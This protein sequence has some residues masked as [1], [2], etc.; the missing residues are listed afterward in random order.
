MITVNN[1]FAH[2]VKEISITKYGSDK[3]LPPKFT[4]W[5]IYQYSDSMLKHLPADSLKIIQKHLLYDKSPI[6]YG[7]TTYDRRNFN[8]SNVVATGS[9]TA[10]AAKK[11]KHTLEM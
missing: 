6:Y 10:D 1:F 2:W 3:E 5:E 8:G 9:S 11:N 7:N 4:P